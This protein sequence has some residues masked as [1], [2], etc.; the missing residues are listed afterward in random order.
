MNDGLL[1]LC[2]AQTLL[3]EN[4]NETDYEA[5]LLLC[6][7]H[8]TRGETNKMLGKYNESK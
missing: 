3:G 2:K 8:S 5:L 1:E 4:L 6:K 7:I